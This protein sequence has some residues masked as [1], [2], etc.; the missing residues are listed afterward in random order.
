MTRWT[1]S[2]LPGSPG[3]EGAGGTHPAQDY[4]GQRLELPEEGPDSVAGFGR[5][6][7]GFVVDILLSGGLAALFTLPEPPGNWSLL[8]WA[9]LTVVPT[10]AFGVTPGMAL[11]GMRVARLG[12]ATFVGVPR[13]LLRTA[14]LFFVL[15]ALITNADGRGLHDR[16]TATVVIRTR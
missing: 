11:L 2:W 14:L 5:R 13:A 10:A 3:Q 16:A 15:P 1:G 9:L 6:T 7:L 8:V 12:D 4:P